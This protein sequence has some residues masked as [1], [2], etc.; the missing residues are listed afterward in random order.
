MSGKARHR[1]LDPRKRK[2]EDVRDGYLSRTGHEKSCLNPGGPPS[3]AKY[4]PETDS[5][6]VP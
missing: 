5:V 4:Y 3:K 2:S 1:G 6:P